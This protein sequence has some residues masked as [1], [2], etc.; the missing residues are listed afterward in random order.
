MEFRTR[1]SRIANCWIALAALIA[2]AA[3]AI[4]FTPTGAA[5]APADQFEF[6]SRNDRYLHGGAGRR[7]QGRLRAKVAP[8]A[9]ARGSPAANSPAP[10]AAIT[11]SHNWGG[12]KRRRAIHLHRARRCRPPPRLARRGNLRADRR[13]P[14]AIERRAA[15]RKRASHR[16]ASARHDD[17]SARRHA[18]L[19]ADDAALAARSADAARRAAQP[20]RENHA[21]HATRSENPPASEWL[22]WRRTYDDHG[23]SPLKQ[24]NK[25]N[26][27]DLRV[28]W[29]W[30][31]PQRP[32]R[33][34]ATRA[35]W[36]LIRR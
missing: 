26:V 14:A 29:A 18:A 27:G 17:N 15:R 13:L 9:T 24:I 35:R 23:F 22:I 4:A 21:R 28:A 34:H 1:K 20:A 33:S 10:S 25:S 32:K 12:Q 5:R 36:R 11:F 3:G 31:L 2:A 8:P 30:S 16:R 7:R 19:R 6:N